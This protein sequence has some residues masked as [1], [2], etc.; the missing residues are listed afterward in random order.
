MEN[1][2][3]ACREEKS[4]RGFSILIVIFYSFQYNEAMTKM[5]GT[6]MPYKRYGDAPWQF[7]WREFC[8]L[9]TGD[10][11]CADDGATLSACAL[12]GQAKRLEAI[13][14]ALTGDMQRHY[15][16]YY[17]VHAQSFGWLGWAKNGAPAGT[18]GYAKKCLAEQNLLSDRAEKGKN[19]YYVSD[20]V[21][22][23]TENAAHFLQEEVSGAVYQSSW[24]KEAGC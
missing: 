8:L 14:I 20:S 6:Y 12:S 7:C 4:V 16:V 9:R 2:C 10:E 19:T 21:S 3:T 18:A 17:R 15:D 1:V 13:C 11:Q 22:L 23:F 24:Q 5:V